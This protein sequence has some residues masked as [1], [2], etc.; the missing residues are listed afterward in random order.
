MA[1]VMDLYVERIE[2]EEYE[3]EGES[4][5]RSRST[6]EEIAVK[7][8]AEPERLVVRATHHGP[9]VNEALRRRARRAA[10]AA[11]VG[12]RRCPAS[13]RPASASST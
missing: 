8:R 1:D 9:I 10:G 3:F 7:G 13:P 11:L 5:S 4:G 12:A 6:E 2:G